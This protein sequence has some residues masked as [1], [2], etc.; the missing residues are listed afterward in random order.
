MQL[1][2][3]GIQI[4]A[5][6]GSI[7]FARREQQQ[8]LSHGTKI[9]HFR[10]FFFLISRISRDE[11]LILI[12]N[13]RAPPRVDEQI[14]TFVH[15][16]HADFLGAVDSRH[17]TSGRQQLQRVA[18]TDI[19]AV[20]RDFLQRGFADEQAFGFGAQAD[21]GFHFVGGV[22]HG[23]DDEEPSEEIRGD[24]VGR[25]D[26]FGAADRAPPAVRGQD[27]DGRNGRLERAVEVGEAFD[28]EHVYL[29]CVLLVILVLE[30]TYGG[31]GGI[32]DAL[33]RR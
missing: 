32:W 22:G 30:L 9:G 24:A 6:L 23:G 33:L 26:V 13:R 31:R 2:G 15:L 28:V 11:P 1:A 3:W 7:W 4:R 12:Y 16:I 25:D 18:Q 29:F 8:N 20:I 19:H 10:L 5:L 14:L 17:D 21:D 27:D